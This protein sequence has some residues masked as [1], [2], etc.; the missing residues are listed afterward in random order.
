LNILLERIFFAARNDILSNCFQEGYLNINFLVK[1]KLSKRKK[2]LKLIFCVFLMESAALQQSR[3]ELYFTHSRHLEATF[4]KLGQELYIHGTH[5]VYLIQWSLVASLCKKWSRNRDCD[6]NRVR[7]MLDFH[8][9]GGHIPRLIHLAL[10][11]DEGLV[12]YDGNHRREV[13]NARADGDLECV[14]DVMFN[15]TQKDVFEAF[16]NIN[17]SVQLPAI[18][19]EDT[20]GTSNVK[21]DI[22]NLVKEYETN[23]KLFLS[24]SARC[25]SPH[26]NRDLFT[27]NIH[28]IYKGFNGTVSIAEIR[29]ILIR[30]NEEYANQNLC[31]LHEKYKKGA[32]AK[33][34]KHNF[35]L[36]LERIIPWEHVNKVREM[37]NY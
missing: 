4:K 35:W 9:K 11:E 5:H 33:C 7:E 15:V 36:F 34:R 30:L 37:G 17:K 24:P 23:Y 1:M 27:E 28:D 19:I 2:F 22:L 26:F 6:V 29:L 12:A 13:F 32:L 18:Y 8:D 3:Q 16:T 21:L 14:V 10:L 25:Q 20:R 31:Q